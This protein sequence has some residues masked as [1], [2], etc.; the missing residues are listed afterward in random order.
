MGDVF[1]YKNAKKISLVPY[2]DFP[3]IIL[4][5]E[6]DRISYS[7]IHKFESNEGIDYAVIGKVFAESLTDT[8]KD[9][10][11]FVGI[12][13]D[14]FTERDLKKR[15]EIL[16]KLKLSRYFKYVLFTQEGYDL[17]KGKHLFTNGKISKTVLADAYEENG[18]L[19]FSN[20][21]TESTENKVSEIK[22]ENGRTTH[23]EYFDSFEKYEENYFIN[24]RDLN[25]LSEES[26][27][28]Y[29]RNNYSR[30]VNYIKQNFS[31]FYNNI[32]RTNEGMTPEERMMYMS[33]ILAVLH[34]AQFGE[35]NTKN[36]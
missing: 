12:L 13:S 21:F 9:Y 36:F 34:T 5:D 11:E 1:N 23:I 19:V 29:V 3:I 22:H 20:A 27:A 18:N 17:I 35:N 30:I 28:D 25:N 15:Y 7:I 26:S 31:S 32:L 2:Y 6:D 24:S 4:K 16:H 10:K 8:A 14:L 33:Q